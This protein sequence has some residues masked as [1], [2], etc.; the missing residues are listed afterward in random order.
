MHHPVVAPVRPRPLL[1]AVAVVAACALLLGLFA[2]ESDAGP[3]KPSLSKQR[4]LI[5]LGRRLFFEP[6][7]SQSGLRSCASCH[8]PDHGFSDPDRVSRDDVGLTRRHSQTIVDTARNPSA[9]WDGEFGSVQELVVARVGGSPTPGH[10][11]GSAGAPGGPFTAPGLFGRR[12]AGAPVTG[13]PEVT[14]AGLS[15]RKAR[16]V[17]RALAA[18]AGREI[19]PQ[20]LDATGR[21]AEAFR[22]TFR[23]EHIKLEQMAE[24]IAAY[25]DSV[26]S[27]ESPFDRHLAGEPDALS[28]SARRGLALFEGRAGC[29][30]CHFTTGDRPALTDFEFHNSGV[31]WDDAR[32]EPDADTTTGLARKALRAHIRKHI[33]GTEAAAAALEALMDGGREGISKTGADRRKFKTPT[34]RDVA[35]RGPYMH[36]GRFETLEEVVRYYATGCGADPKKDERLKPF[37]A[38]AADIEDLVAFM[39]SLTGDERPGLAKKAWSKRAL[40]TRLRFVDAEGRPLERMAVRIQPEGDPI[41]VRRPDDGR[42]LEADTNSGGWIRYAPPATTHARIVLPDGI[43][44]VGGALVPDTCES[45][46]VEVPVAGRATVVLVL[47][48]DRRAPAVIVATH[49]G[50][51]GADQA[52]PRTRLTRRGVVELAT[53]RVAR[54][55]A[56]VR[57]D[58]KPDVHLQ[59]PG[60]QKSRPGRV[61]PLAV[62]LVADEEIRL[63]LSNR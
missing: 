35:R 23:T 1:A 50:A 7:A 11:Y 27:T 45:A 61:P 5:E 21:Y 58:V 12:R 22:A 16:R 31:A 18:F 2:G 28:A 37:A 44:P 15:G 53:T 38:T 43:V 17:S 9:H 30:Q 26:E 34:L 4:R 10:G 63:D 3:R 62:T 19:V 14:V 41:P 42:P 32:H 46:T 33:D 48:K 8:A 39:E 47:P 13:A 57:T 54:Y 60:W 40:K 49:P 29:A 56:W 52:L 6:Q 55:E 20:R 25:C 51:L 24:A 59:L 36:N